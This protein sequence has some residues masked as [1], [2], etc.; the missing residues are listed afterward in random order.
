MPGRVAE[1]GQIRSAA[2]EEA[3]Q[4]DAQST[5]ARQR[6]RHLPQDAALD[7]AYIRRTRRNAAKDTRALRLLN[8][9]K[10]SC[11]HGYISAH[12]RGQK[13]HIPPE[14]KEERRLYPC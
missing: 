8:H 7:E 11:A 4:G 14:V 13:Q 2:R 6:P 9:G 1:R 12:R 10:P 5:Q 3:G